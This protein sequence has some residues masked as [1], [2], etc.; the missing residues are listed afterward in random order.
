MRPAAISLGEIKPN[1][2]GLGDRN[3]SFLRTLLKDGNS[4][5]IRLGGCVRSLGGEG[6]VK[7]T[8]RVLKGQPTEVGGRKDVLTIWSKDSVRITRSAKKG[9]KKRRRNAKARSNS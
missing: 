6:E 9:G 3:Q 8:T 7:L 4:E 2:S 1:G 5:K